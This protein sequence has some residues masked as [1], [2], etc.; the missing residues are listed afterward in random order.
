MRILVC[1]GRDYFNVSAVNH[2]LHAVHK[3][4]PITCIIEGGANGADRLARE[5]AKS[6]GIPVQT[7]EA[8]WS[9]YGR[10]A[11]PLRNYKMLVEG[12][13]DGVIAF[14]GGTGTFDMINQAMKKGIKVWQPF[15]IKET[16]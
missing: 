12:K 15:A 4:K 1:G 11:G 8:D 16:A 5:W 6:S 14:P 10:R 13:P 2:V 7:F 3:R 9:K